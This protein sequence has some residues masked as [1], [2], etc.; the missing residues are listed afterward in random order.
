MI[1]REYQ[2]KGTKIKKP[3]YDAVTE[4]TALFTR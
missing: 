2:K 4:K 3:G 1:C